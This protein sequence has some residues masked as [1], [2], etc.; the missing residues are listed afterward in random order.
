[1]NLPGRDLTPTMQRTTECDAAIVARF[2]RRHRVQDAVASVLRILL[3]PVALLA[4]RRPPVRPPRH[5]LVANAGH[6]GD[7]ILSTCVLEP[8]RR[9]YPGAEIG[10]L[11]GRQALPVLEGHPLIDR[12]HILDHWASVRTNHVLASKL[13]RYVSEAWRTRRELVAVG[14]DMAIDFHV[15]F[16][17]YVVLLAAAGIPERIGTDRFGFSCLLTRQIPYGYARRHEVEGMRALLRAAGVSYGDAAAARPQLKPIPAGAC[18]EAAA[19]VPSGRYVVLHPTASTPVRDWPIEN[20][21]ALARHLIGEG[22]TPVVTGQGVRDATNAAAILAAAPQAVD[23]VGRL[24]W[25]ALGAALSRAE[26]VFCVETSVGHYARAL[27]C[28]VVSIV[29]GMADPVRW[30]PLGAVTATEP[31]PCSPCFLKQ[32]CDGRACLTALKVETVVRLA[33]FAKD[34]V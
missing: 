29:G 27:G 26:T 21:C 13:R 25:Q 33:V 28:P 4:T 31:Q 18:A 3:T 16:P 20:W 11:A 1:M 8:L 10:F 22:V 12:L 30:S 15:W 23:A 34:A 2:R 24:S 6:L 19:V 9:T 7:A 14:Y 17:N 5:I 32:G